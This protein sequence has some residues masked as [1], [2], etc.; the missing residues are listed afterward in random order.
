M[1]ARIAVIHAI[2]RNE[3]PPPFLETGKQS[4]WGKRK[5][6]R[7]YE[8][9][10]LYTALEKSKAV[11]RAGSARNLWMLCKLELPAPEINSPAFGDRI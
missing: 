11:A 8:E 7:D 4:H 6:K 3:A 1:H 10:D 5:L 9:L 2:K